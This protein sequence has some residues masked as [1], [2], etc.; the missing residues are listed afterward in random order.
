M[1]GTAAERLREWRTTE[2]VSQA[3]F[4][5]M[6]G[7]GQTTISNLEQGERNPGL[8]LGLAIEMV[9]GIKASLW[10]KPVKRRRAA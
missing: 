9:T 3:Q 8:S 10:P 7:V 1:T 2:K 4:A 5:E 6:V